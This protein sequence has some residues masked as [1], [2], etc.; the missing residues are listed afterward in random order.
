[1]LR[2]TE[3][4]AVTCGCSEMFLPCRV[5][6]LVKGESYDV[7]CQWF[8]HLLERMENWPEGYQI[9][10]TTE[11]RPALPKMHE[12]GHI[13]EKHER[14]SLQYLLG[15]GMMDGESPERIWAGHNALRKATKTTGPGTRHDVLDDH[16]GWWNWQKYIALLS[17][18]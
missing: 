7:A 10:S 13:R 16:F 15:A 17:P 18:R 4:G 14:L 3:V 1:G 6:N 5:G 2:Y 12:T 9:P 11:I 8:I